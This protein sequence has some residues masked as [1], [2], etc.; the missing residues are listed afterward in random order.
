M[1]PEPDRAAHDD[2]GERA[3]LVFLDAM[4]RTPTGKL[5]RDRLEA[6]IAADLASPPSGS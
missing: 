3:R 1:A 5:D 2:S 4:P 6:Q